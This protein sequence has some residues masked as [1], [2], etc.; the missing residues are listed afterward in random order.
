MKKTMK[1]S[2]IFSLLICLGLFVGCNSI[3]NKQVEATE[4][5]EA[6]AENK[7]SEKNI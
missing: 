3:N 2:I 5:T 6:Q 4:S 7:I 1:I